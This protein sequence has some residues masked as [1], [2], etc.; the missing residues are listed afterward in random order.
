MNAN[1]RKKQIKPKVTIDQNEGSGSKSKAAS[2]RFTLSKIK[3]NR[4]LFIGFGLLLIFAI[5]SYL[6]FKSNSD[7]SN[8]TILKNEVISEQNKKID[9]IETQ[10]SNNNQLLLDLEK[11]DQALLKLES[12]MMELREMLKVI[13]EKNDI[14]SNTNNQLMQYINSE[15]HKKLKLQENALPTGE[16]DIDNIQLLRKSINTEEISDEAKENV[17]ESQE[18][19]LENNLE[20][21]QNEK[22]IAVIVIDRIEKNVANK[23]DFRNEVDLLISIGNDVEA[24]SNLMDLSDK[25]IFTPNELA[26][27]LELLLE[28]DIIL[29]RGESG[30]RSKIFGILENQI[31]ITK[32]N[33]TLEY[34]VIEEIKASIYNDNLDEVV[35]IIK[36]LNFDGDAEALLTNINNR[37]LYLNEIKHLKEMYDLS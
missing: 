19:E 26:L 14:I 27:E 1:T 36:S 3:L 25:T 33:K 29:Y 31:S 35:D 20:G 23:K 8:F 18:I 16:P 7:L 2:K 5:P 21:D 13:S 9:K 32:K 6:F 28:E 4:K 22:N 15:N 34:V 17:S 10:I 30:I 11:K 24:L 12:Q 37:T